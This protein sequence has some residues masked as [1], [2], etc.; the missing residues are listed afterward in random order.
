MKGS[1]KPIDIDYT[2]WLIQDS[3]DK[4]PDYGAKDYLGTETTDYATWREVKEAAAWINAQGSSTPWFATIAFH[5]PHEPF[6]IPPDGFDSATAGSIKAKE[7]YKF[8]IMAQNM[9]YNIGRLLGTSGVKGDF[10]SIGESRLS[11]TII[12]FIGDNG[13]DK[14]VALAE[15]KDEIYEGSVRVPMIIADGQ[16]VM[17]EINGKAITPRFLDASRLNRTYDRMAHVVDLYKTIVHLADSSATGFPSDTDSKSFQLLLKSKKFN[18]V[19]TIN[20]LTP[21]GIELVR[22]FNFSQLYKTGSTKATIRNAAY[23]LNYD[24]SKTP[25]YALYKYS[26]SEI[27]GQEDDDAVDLFTDAISGK[28]AEAQTNLNLLYDELIANYRCDGDENTFPP[29]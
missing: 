18:S 23:K 3:D 20:P 8:N 26:G 16:A 22:D 4:D 17:N 12:I 5:S 29:L 28:N 9:D 1:K 21:I 7:D 25:K 13:S 24:K 11:N 6:H 19:L 10:E 15:E 2:H 27:P 14:E